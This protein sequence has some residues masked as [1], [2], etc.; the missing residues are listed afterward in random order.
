MSAYFD[1]QKGVDLI[2]ISDKYFAFV[3]WKTT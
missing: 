1:M 2:G 3:E